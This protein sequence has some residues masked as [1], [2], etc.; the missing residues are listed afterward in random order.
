MNS[1]R[2]IGYLDVEEQCGC[3]AACID[4]ELLTTACEKRLCESRVRWFK[5]F[6]FLSPTNLHQSVRL[7]ALSSDIDMW[8]IIML[9]FWT[10]FIRAG[11]IFGHGLATWF[12]LLFFCFISKY[13]F[14]LHSWSPVK[15]YNV[16]LCSDYI[17]VKSIYVITHETKTATTN[18]LTTAFVQ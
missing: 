17:D 10:W 9:H 13:I 8:L 1:K 7:F 18:K 16:L 15:M 4:T 11:V 5:R 3:F 2:Q 6:G 12:F 14:F